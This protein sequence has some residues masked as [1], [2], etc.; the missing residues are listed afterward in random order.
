MLAILGTR[1]SWTAGELAER[2]EITERTVRRDI[3]ELRNLGYPVHAAPGAGGGYQL[4]AGGKVPPLLLDDDEAVAV[5]IGLTAMVGAGSMDLAQG[6]VSALS[7]LGRVLP[8][9]L[10]ER[11]AALQRVTLALRRTEIPDADVDVV[12]KIAVACERPERLRFDYLD[13][14]EVS[15]HRHVEPYRLVFTDRRWYLVAYDTGRQAWRTFRVD[16][17]TD[18]ETGGITFTRSGELPDATAQVAAGVALWGYDFQARVRFHA[19]HDDVVRFVD[20]TIG[21]LDDEVDGCTV[22]RIGGDADWIARYLASSPYRFEVIDSPEV[23]DELCKLGA[24]L[25]RDH[26]R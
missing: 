18:I 25:Q 15:S 14:R 24:R 8:P 2:L 20:A 19:P 12:V 16:R 1:P 5:A 23:D 6:A 10:R 17:M 11:V 13:A 7:K 22:A 9:R 26:R 4:G 21:V 3:T